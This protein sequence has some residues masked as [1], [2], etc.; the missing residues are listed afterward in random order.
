MTVE[1]WDGLDEDRNARD[2]TTITDA[3]IDDTITV[4]IAVRDRDEPPAVPT[5]TVTSPARDTT[6]RR[7]LEVFWDAKNTGPDI[8]PSMTCNTARA[9]APS[10]TITATP[11][12]TITALQHNRHDHHRHT[13]TTITTTIT[14]LEE[15]TSYSVQVRATNA[16]GTS[17]WSRVVT[18]KTNKGTNTP[19]TF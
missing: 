16:E 10:Q 19:P 6:I 17:A 5:V 1:V 13:L 11:W 15:D 18:V 9:A 3:I 7:Y 8:N 12:V 14:G 4:K 2:T